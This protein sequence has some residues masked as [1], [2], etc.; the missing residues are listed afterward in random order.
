MTKKLESA[1]AG[2]RPKNYTFEQ[3]WEVVD[4]MIKSGRSV[5]E[6]NARSVK[7]LLREIYGVKPW[8]S[9]GL[10]RD[11]CGTRPDTSPSI[12]K[13]KVTVPPGMLVICSMILSRIF[14]MSVAG[15]S[16]EGST[17]P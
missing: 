10:P 11:G 1:S 13:R 12:S 4:Q 14:L 2:G 5:E 7:P 16:E 17:T 3:V 15:R 9:G 6:I 8:Y